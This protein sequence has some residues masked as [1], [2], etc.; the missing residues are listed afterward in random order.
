MRGLYIHVPFCVKKCDYCDFVSYS[1]CFDMEKDY[2]KA[3]LREFEYY[4]GEKID[5]VYIG[6]GTPTSLKCESLT[7]ILNGVFSCFCVAQNGEVT[8]ECNPKTADKEKF[9]RLADSG[10]NRLSIGIQSADDKILSEIGRIHTKAD[11]EKCIMYGLDAGFSNIS[12]DLMFGLPGQSVE[13]VIKSVDF[14]TSMPINHISCYGLILEE[15]TPLYRRVKAGEVS[16]PDEDTEFF[17]YRKIS[18]K[19]SE[20]GFRRYEISNFSK[21]GFESRHNRKYWDAKEY[22][23]CGAAAH[24]YYKGERFCHNADLSGYIKNPLERQEVCH[25]SDKDKM[26]EFM[27]LG[28]RKGEGVDNKEF[29]KRFKKS[30]FDEYKPIIERFAKIGLLE[31]DGDF[32]KL[33]EQGVYVSNTVLCEFV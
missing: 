27:I 16:L 15:G 31:V 28:L 23:G 6:G 4:R 18:E 1:G 25:L 12:A 11:G 24:S 26:C 32:L 30:L 22:I 2:V 14:L 20:K 5:T 29:Y 9:L 21:C 17:M 8:V 10:V 3:L 13:S 7:E 33:T 19:L